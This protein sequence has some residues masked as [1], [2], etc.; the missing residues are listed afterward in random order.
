[1]L[2]GRGTKFPTVPKGDEAAS[3]E[4]YAEAQAAVDR[5]A[6]ADF[7]VK[8]LS[9]VGTDL[10]SIERVTG[11][12]SWGRAAG[13]GALSGLWFGMFLGLLF[14]IVTPTDQSF[15]VLFAALLLGAGFGMLFG[16][17]TYTIN[18]RR[19]DFTSV[20]Q[21]AAGRYALIVEPGLGAR[22]REILGPDA[23]TAPAPAPTAATGRTYEQATAERDASSAPVPPPTRERP[24]YGE[25]AESEDAAEPD[26]ADAERGE[27]PSRADE[28]ATRDGRG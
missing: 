25:L 7:P 21:V 26:V 23:S 12:M 19:R 4:T 3:F 10:T 18:R 2:G 24:R 9:I 8:Q 22:A 20:M 11:R 6:R 16:L 27:S 28:P 5:L 13:A 15:G 14:F 1:M 17:V